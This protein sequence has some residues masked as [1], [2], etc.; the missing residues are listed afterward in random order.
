MTTPRKQPRKAVADERPDV[1]N[2]LAQIRQAL[3]MLIALQH[4]DRKRLDR[5][6]IKVM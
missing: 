5:L 6:W 3:D 4:E 1:S 2:E